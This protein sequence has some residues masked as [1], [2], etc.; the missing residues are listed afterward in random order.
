MSSSD[1]SLLGK[2]KKKIPVFR[3]NRPYLNLLVNPRKY[4]DFRKNLIL[5]ILKGVFSR[6]KYVYLPYLNFSDPLTDT[7]LFIIWPY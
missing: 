1:I 4:Q 3:V 5:C 7:H 6:K 2:I